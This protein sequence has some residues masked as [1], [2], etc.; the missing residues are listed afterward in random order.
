MGACR[1]HPLLTKEKK[2][3]RLPRSFILNR[4]HNWSICIYSIHMGS[5][6]LHFLF[7][8]RSLTRRIIMDSL[9]QALISLIATLAITMPI[10]VFGWM[11]ATMVTMFIFFIYAQQIGD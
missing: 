8:T 7:H 3:G 6:F 2:H 11:G 9:K 10:Y 4:H 1:F 5:S